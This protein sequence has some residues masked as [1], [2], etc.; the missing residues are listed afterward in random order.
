[1]GLLY[2]YPLNRNLG[3]IHTCSRR[4][5]DE[6]L[7]RPGVEPRFFGRASCSV[8]IV[9]TAESR[10]SNF[11]LAVP[12]TRTGCTETLTDY[13]QVKILKRGVFQFIGI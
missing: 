5:G 3:G 13:Y 9:L 8:V 7:S 6:F 12:N 11:L 2:L 4:L 1:M 10:I